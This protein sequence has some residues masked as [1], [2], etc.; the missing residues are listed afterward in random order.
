MSDRIAQSSPR[1]WARI[2][3]VLYL[4]VIVA[5]GWAQL[6][7]RAHLIVRDDAAATA[8]N[9]LAREPLFRLGFAADLIGVVCY[10]GVVFILYELLKPVGR[11]VSLLAAFFGMA[12]NA[13]FAINLLNHLAAAIVLDNAHALAA[14][15]PDQLQALALVFLKL[16]TQG[17]LIVMVFFGFYL[18]LLGV[19]I[20]RSA[21]LPRILGALLVVGGLADVAGSFAVF[22]STAF[23][24]NFS[25]AATALGGIAE[26]ALALWLLVVGVNAAKWLEQADAVR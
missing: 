16:H 1:M 21:F 18:A 14:F 26:I 24:A 19:L 2:A 3:G 15:R 11:S 8:A 22:I 25:P 23:A 20:C 10:V 6:F 9:I 17:Y 12:G 5:G 4:I 13:I 7:V